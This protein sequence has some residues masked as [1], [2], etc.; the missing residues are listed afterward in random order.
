MTGLEDAEDLMGDINIEGIL[1]NLPMAAR[2]IEFEFSR[3]GGAKMVKKTEEHLEAEKNLRGKEGDALKIT[4]R[5]L[6]KQRRRY[7]ARRII[8]EVQKANKKLNACHELHCEKEG[9]KTSDRQKWKEELERYSRKKYQDDGMNAKAK[10]EL[11]EWEERSRR[12]RR[13]S[14]GSQEPKLTMS[15]IMQSR[16]SFSNGK[17]VGIDGISAEIVKSIPWTALQKIEKAFE[18]RYTGENKEEIET[19][20]RNIIVLIPKEKVIDKLEGQTRRICVQSVLAKWYCGC[21]TILLE[22]ELRNVEKRDTSWD[23]VHTFGFEDGRSAA[24]KTVTCGLGSVSHKF[25]QHPGP[26]VCGQKFGRVCRK[27]PTN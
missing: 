7:K 8:Q 18:R 13:D 17:A 4:K 22:M 19:W 21:L 6:T 15:V 9:G 1:E 27:H 25:K 20:L 26:V 23:E 14:E 5:E 12:Q 16:A 11:E 2:A 10:K 24:S 3:G